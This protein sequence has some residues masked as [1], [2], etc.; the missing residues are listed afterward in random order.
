[1]TSDLLVSVSAARLALL[2]EALGRAAEGDFDAALPGLDGATADEFGE[3]ERAV[4]GL[5]TDFRL[6]IEQNA[7]SIEEFSA[8]KRELLDKLD[9]IEAQHAAIQ[10]LSAPI[11][12]VWDG[13]V[14]VPLSGV[15]DSSGAQELTARLLAW[16]HREHT[17]WVV[18]DLTG[19]TQLDR[20]IAERLLRLSSAVGLMGARCMVTGIGPQIAQILVSLGVST[21]ALRPVASLKEGLKLCMS[22]A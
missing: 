10:R 2:R 19:A 6:A 12:D 17:A 16:I 11:I 8:S 5:I 3:I 22:R 7:L 14:T 18:L 21:D 4:R 1:M 20:E 15:L 9:T 13:V